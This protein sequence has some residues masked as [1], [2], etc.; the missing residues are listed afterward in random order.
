MKYTELKIGQKKKEKIII[1]EDNVVMYSILYGD[2]NPV[3][4]D[5]GYA[6]KTIFKER[7]AHGMLVM[8]YISSILGNALPGEGSIYLGQDI[9]FTAP[10]FLGDE[11]T[12]EVTI[13][14]LIKEKKHAILA[15]NVYNSKG[16]PVILGSA[17]LKVQN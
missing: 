2:K 13:T 4:T 12:I 14:Q 8:S 16:E 10:V 1:T 11:I 7:I 6:K 5:K 17:R 3:H 15:T 9:K